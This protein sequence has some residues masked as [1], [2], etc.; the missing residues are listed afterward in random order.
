MTMQKLFIA[1]IAIAL[2]AGS[3]AASGTTDVMATVRQF[4]DAF[5]KSDVKALTATSADDMAIIDEFPP[6]EW[7]GAGALA[8]WLADYEVDARKEGITDGRVT[9]GR[10]RHVDIAADRAY[11]VIPSNYNYKKKGKRVKETGSLW[12]FA[13]QKGAAGWRITGWSWAKN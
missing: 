7:H 2:T 13:L 12:T 4:A 8:K 11:V 5:N 9:L 6:Y 10:P 3:A 1:L